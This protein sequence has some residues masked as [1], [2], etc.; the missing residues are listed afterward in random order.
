MRVST[1]ARHKKIYVSGKLCY[2]L[3]DACDF[4]FEDIDEFDFS[5]LLNMRPLQLETKKYGRKE[6][7]IKICSKQEGKFCY[8]LYRI[9][10]ELHFP[11]DARK[12]WLAFI[13]K[14]TGVSESYCR[15]YN[16]RITKKSKKNS[17]NIDNTEFI[18]AVSL[19]FEKSKRG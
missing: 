18:E 17:E 1:S 19:A 6:C 5:D 13:C 16:K 2:Y 8:L 9:A 15:S 4:L 10:D 11:M 3:Y 14:A 12:E 7:I